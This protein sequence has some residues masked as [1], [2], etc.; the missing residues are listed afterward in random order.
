MPI[1]HFHPDLRVRIDL[2]A[3][4]KGGRS[5]PLRGGEFRTVFGIEGAH[6]S[7]RLALPDAGLDATM[8]QVIEVQFLA[9]DARQHFPLGASFSVWEGRDI[10][11][12]LVLE[13]L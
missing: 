5:T 8:S 3:A 9:E 7:C 1:E 12:G 6:W 11:S 10:G 4:S 13:V 2:L